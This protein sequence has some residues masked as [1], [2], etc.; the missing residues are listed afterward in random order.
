MNIGN[1]GPH[2]LE[3]KRNRPLGWKVALAELVDNAF[4]AAA[5]RVVIDFRGPRGLVVTDDGNGCGNIERMLTIAD[6][7]HTASTRLGRYGVGLKDAGCWLWGELSIETVHRGVTMAARVNWPALVKQ[8]TWELD[9]PICYQPSNDLPRGTRLAFSKYE[10][11]NPAI[12]QLAADLGYTFAPGISQG[13]QVVIVNKGKPKPVTPWTPPPMADVVE[14]AF[15]VDGKQ[16]TLKAGIVPADDTNPKAGFNF[17][18]GHR[19]IL[20]SSLGANGH[21]TSRVCGVVTLGDGWRLSTNKT[22]LCGDQESLG[23]AIY[24]RCKSLLVKADQQAQSIFNRELEDAVTQSLRGYLGSPRRE[25]RDKGESV[26][27]V[28]PKST[29]RTRRKAAQIH[30][31]PGQIEQAINAGSIR[32]EFRNLDDGRLGA[33]DLPGNLIVLNANHRRLAS[34]REAKNHEALVDNCM[35]LLASAVFEH[36]QREKFPFARDHDTMID[37][38]SHVLNAQAAM[39]TV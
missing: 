21:S 13:R 3:D 32:F 37:A 11:P 23:D 17:A 12:D 31:L 30:D 8:N 16:V 26:G 1:I 18:Y 6:H 7:V 39:A 38:L 33:V 19:N 9:D 2:V 27:A 4:D 36:S 35:T 22:E 29:G 15:S 25:K 28:Q 14:D 24:E 5:T 10:R 34:H 20:N